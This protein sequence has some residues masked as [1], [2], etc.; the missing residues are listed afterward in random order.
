MPLFRHGP[1]YAW[2]ALPGV[3]SYVV[4]PA[5]AQASLWRPGDGGAENTS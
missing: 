3:A 1:G 4:T 5:Q 2:P